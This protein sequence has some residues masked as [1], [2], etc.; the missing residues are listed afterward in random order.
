MQYDGQDW[1]FG[2]VVQ[3]VQEGPVIGLGKLQIVRLLLHVN[4]T[5]GGKVGLENG[6]R[7]E[8]NTL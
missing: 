8:V 1:N 4:S 7:G 5:D 3:A 6:F 2:S